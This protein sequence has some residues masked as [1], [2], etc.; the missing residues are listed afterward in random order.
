MQSGQIVPRNSLELPSLPPLE[1]AHI[2]QMHAQP[3]A[4][5]HPVNPEQQKAIRDIMACRTPKLGGHVEVCEHRCGF[6]RLSFNSCRNRHCP[7]CQSLQKARWI[8]NRSEKLLPTHYFH[9][10]L[11]L[12]HELGP[13]ILRNPVR[14]YNMLFQTASQAL[15][16]LAKGWQRLRAQVGFTAVLHTWD[17]ELHHHPHL[18]MVVPAGGLDLSGRRWIAAKDNFLVPVRALSKLFRGKFLDA[19]QNAFLAGELSFS[20]ATEHLQ[21]PVTFKRLVK[22]LRGKKWVAYCKRPF[23]GPRQVF[24]YLGHYTHRVAISNHRLVDF[25]GQTVTFR[26]RN[27]EDPGTYRLVPLPAQEFTRRFLLH[28]LPPGFVRI[29]HYGLLAP[30]NANT[31]LEKARRLI[32][33][34]RPTPDHLP[35][36][37]TDSPTD[38]QPLT[39]QELL[40]QLTGVDVT[41]C[42]N[43]GAKLLRKT[44]TTN[45]YLSALTPMSI[46]IHDSS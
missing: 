36:A 13:L 29:R 31:K 40:L 3:Y 30:K 41:V 25:D 22:D 34:S 26:A 5:S 20:G 23:G 18:H 37:R 15:L 16:E 46:P 10:V 39:W 9:V 32:E 7:K 12:P 35:Y 6:S 44:L 1:L 27:N 42:P 17:Q 4:N 28:V 21:R 14:L 45:L 2:F 43:C 19:F 11:T 33:L 38:P 8:I 24:S